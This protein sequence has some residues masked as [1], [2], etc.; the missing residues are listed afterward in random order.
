M[1][2]DELGS[3]ADRPRSRQDCDRERLP[4]GVTAASC[5]CAPTRPR[6]EEMVFDAHDRALAFFQ[7]RLPARHLRQHEDGGARGLRRQGPPVQS[8]LPPD[9]LLHIVEPVACTPALQAHKK[10][11]AREPGRPHDSL[12]TTASPEAAMISSLVTPDPN[13][14]DILP[15]RVT[16]I[17]CAML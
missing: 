17:R 9:V 5:S 2:Y 4:L 11:E 13:C 16:M 10:G 8:P 1:V 12:P 15:P 14:A 6:H 3:S 7:G